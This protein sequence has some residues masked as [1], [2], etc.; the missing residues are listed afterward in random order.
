MDQTILQMSGI[1]HAKNRIHILSLKIIVQDENI[2][3]ILKRTFP[4]HSM[5]CNSVSSIFL[6]YI[7]LSRH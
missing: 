2:N 3:Y 5:Y 6:K 1:D 7:F 4:V